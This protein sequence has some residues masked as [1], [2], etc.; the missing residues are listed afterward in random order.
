M[1]NNHPNEKGNDENV[2]TWKF[3]S[4]NTTNRKMMTESKHRKMKTEN[5]N[6]N[7]KLKNEINKD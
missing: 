2:N 4:A 1:E 3:E 5:K 6:N 7:M